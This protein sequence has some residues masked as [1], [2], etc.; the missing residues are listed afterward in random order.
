MLHCRRLAQY[1][2]VLTLALFW[3]LHSNCSVW[4]IDFLMAHQ[5]IIGHSVPVYDT[6]LNPTVG[7]CVSHDIL[8]QCKRINTL[9]VSQE[10]G[11]RWRKVSSVGVFYAFYQ[12]FA[13]PSVLWQYCAIY[14]LPEQ[15]QQLLLLHTFNGLFSRTTWVSQHQKGKPF[16]ILLEEETMARD[17][18][19]ALPSAGSYTNHVN[20]APDSSPRLYLTTQAGCASC[21]RTNS[22]KALEAQVGKVEE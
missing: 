10:S 14:S 12:C 21:C 4:V 19:V 16:C 5:H 2:Y 9:S 8:L 1:G 13:F 15:Q 6:G 3:W 18:G 22:I 20:L 11:G 7:S 17:N